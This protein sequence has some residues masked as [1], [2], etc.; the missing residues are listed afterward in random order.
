MSNRQT[1]ILDFVSNNIADCK[2]ALKALTKAK[3]VLTNGKFDK[4]ID[5][6]SIEQLEAIAT[7]A[8]M[9]TDYAIASADDTAD[10]IDS[11]M[12][13][14][15]ILTHPSTKEDGTI[16]T[17]QYILLPYLGR[18]GGKQ[19]NFH[20]KY[21]NT[22]VSVQ[23]TVTMLVL[24]RAQPFVEGQLYAIKAGLNQD[25]EP[26]LV[27]MPEYNGVY[28][29]SMHVGASNKLTFINDKRKQAIPK[30][31]AI[32]LAIADSGDTLTYEQAE[33]IYMEDIEE[34]ARK[35]FK[36]SKQVVDFSDI[37]LD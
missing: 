8:N 37:P 14:V 23:P 7:E 35:S 30:S 20:F 18:S 1:L 15:K 21:G 12:D 27:F 10:E 3:A 4:Y 11:P 28:S 31:D 34:S 33:K 36:A 24:H 2:Q 29:G 5:N 13:G 16:S 32:K 6:A 9:P 19:Q 25:G 26:N 22:K 17:S